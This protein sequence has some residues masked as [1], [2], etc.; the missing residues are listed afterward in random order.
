VP[1]LLRDPFA[2]PS[3][4]ITF[5]FTD[6]EGSTSAW[7]RSPQAMGPA[8]ARHDAIIEELVAAH[9]GHI[10]RPRGEGDSRFA[11]FI[12]AS[13]AVTAASAIQLALADEPW[14]LSQ[15]LR[16]RIAI[17]T[18]DAELRHGDYYG[19]AVNHCARLRAVAHGGQVL[20]SAVTADLIHEG[21]LPSGVSLRNLGPHLL[22]DFD[23]PEHVWQVVHPKLRSEFP[24][25]TAGSP[26]RHNLPNEL[27]SFVGRARDIAELCDLLGAARLLTLT[28]AGGIGKTR[29]ALRVATEVLADY[30]DGVWVVRLEALADPDLVPNATA[31]VLGAREQLGRPLMDAVVDTIGSRQ[32]LLVL[33]NCEHLLYACAVVADA[34]LQACPRLKILVTSREALGVQGEVAWRVRPLSLP[35]DS[36]HETLAESEAGRLF[37]ERA[38]AARPEFALT[39]LNAPAIAQVCRQ[40]DGLPLA[41]ELAAARVKALSVEQVASRLADRF[42]LLTASTRTGSPR[43]KTLQAAIDWSYDL[44]SESERLLFKRLGVFVGGWTLEAAEAVCSG[45]GIAVEEVLDTLCSLVDK[46]LATTVERDGYVRYRLLESIRQYALQRLEASGEAGTVRRRHTEYHLAF[47]EQAEPHLRAER[48]AWWLDQLEAEHD[49]L[50]AALASCVEDADAECGLRFGAALWRFWEVHGHLTEGR[51]R[52]GAVLSLP[53]PGEGAVR[54]ARAAALNAAGNLAWHQGEYA[55]ARSAHQESL[56]IRRE[57]GDQWGVAGSLSNLGL[58]AALEGDFALARS[59]FHDSLMIRRE[60]GDQWGIAVTNNNLGRCAQ[61]QGDY[62]LARSHH[63][64]SLTISRVLGDRRGVASALID[65]GKIAEQQADFATAWSCYENGLSISRELGNK[66]YIAE[67]LEGI[68]TLAAV[69]A[70]PGRALRLA[71]AAAALR[72]V[73]GA[74]LPTAE[75]ER[76]DRG[77]E[78]A[79]QMLTSAASASAWFEGQSMTLEAALEYACLVGEKPSGEQPTDD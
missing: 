62:T 6:V 46:S 28:G 26:T 76:L 63:E 35:V 75:L 59:F 65:L 17:H 43:L 58:V 78:P 38:A 20:V 55:L 68:A 1:H 15:P 45:D 27:S 57:L 47:A 71:A 53:V 48:Q 36:G 44:L 9:S 52:L 69:Q 50:R 73:I 3:G 61:Q 34:L 31:A 33:D 39:T 67:A 12:R 24:P 56:T 29:L 14:P 30:A 54:A 74:R 25:L 42:Q 72:D 8:L 5:L 41:I 79:R 19:P 66:E 49:N 11:V 77:L 64:E 22:K 18:G 13:D 40:L 37:L 2:L 32:L 51:E 7:L 60:L 23:R 21:L 70:Q 4:T 10:V 16:V